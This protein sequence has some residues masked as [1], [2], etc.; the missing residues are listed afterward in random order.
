MPVT[1][2]AA[3]LTSDFVTVDGSRRII[4]G[5]I[6]QNA[7]AAQRRHLAKLAAARRARR[8]VAQQ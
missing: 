1:S 3:G 2:T 5:M 7:K 8:Q 4:A 6:R